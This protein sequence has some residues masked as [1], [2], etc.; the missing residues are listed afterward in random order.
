MHEKRHD[1]FFDEDNEEAKAEKQLLTM[2]PVYDKPVAAALEV[3]SKVKG[4]IIKITPESV[5]V[6]IG[7]KNEAVI[8]SR[9][10]T[11]EDGSL[12]V[13]VGDA[14]EAYVISLKG[15]IM[16]STKL[17]S[18]AASD[19]SLADI[20]NAMNARLPVEG[21]VTGV[22]KGGFNV[23]IM[24]QRA[25]CP[26]SHI[27]LKRV[28]DTSAYLNRVF[29][30][31]ITRV[32]ENGRNIVVSR[33]PLLEEEM[34]SA[35][36]AIA[37]NVA[38]KAVITGAITRIMPFGLFVDIGGFEGLVH[39]SEVSWERAEDLSKSFAIGQSVDCVVLGIEKKDPL[40]QSKIS[41]SL[42]QVNANPWTTVGS[43]F[44]AGQSV[45]GKITRLASFGA[46]VQLIPGVEG[47]IH[48]SEMSWEK[49]V[50]HP[51]DVV[52]EGQAVTVTILSIDEAK[53]EISC[54]LRDL[55]ADPWNNIESRFATGMTVRGMV[56][57]ST[58]FGY[59]IDLSPGIT[60]LLPFGNIA[61]DK[62]DT[63]KTGG[64]LDVVIES[65]DTERRRISLSFGTSE[66]K[67]QAAEVKQYLS[68]QAQQNPPQEA[69]GTEFGAALRSALEK[70]K[71]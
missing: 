44:A 20:I 34:G 12:S 51:S 11:K 61:Q 48:I 68:S 50:R 37:G 66:E 38:S 49:K 28:E 32:T 59:F 41:L 21:K 23:K 62:K 39:I 30:F 45:P 26:V 3:G 31:V 40:R 9:E 14:I 46:F 16:L 18:K 57:Q 15:G 8:E 7:G 35:L 70:K 71:P 17:S 42:K 65:V 56:A 53:H 54:S 24:G 33:L 2:I 6:E 58:K 4:K 55:A 60:G 27:D 43:V 64:P 52:S 69:R 67:S 63:I 19:S 29:S 36:D 47:L 1:S 10:M 25:F 22:N 5:F 13:T